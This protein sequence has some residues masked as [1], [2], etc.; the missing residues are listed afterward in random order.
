MS[1]GSSPRFELQHDP[2]GQLVLVD[3]NGVRHTGVGPVR[4]FP[5]SEPDHWISICDSNGRELAVVQDL[6]TLSPAVRTILEQ[7]L[8]K[9][10]FVPL[11]RRIVSV[12]S[13]SEPTEWEVE[14]DR[15]RTRFEL[16]SAD[17]VRRLGAERALVIDAR[18]I[19]YLIEDIRS[20]DALSRRV[21]ERYL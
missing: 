17:D 5:I 16:A 2:A 1:N 13:D 21:L 7:D 19:R 8:A 20:L 12:P 15:G 10:E 18:G 3:A 11:I 14:T 9:R 6:N 4:S